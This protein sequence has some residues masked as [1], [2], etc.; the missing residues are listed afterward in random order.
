MA[1]ELLQKVLAARGGLNRWSGFSTV[2]GT[3]VTGAALRH[4]GHAPQD[5]TPRRVTVSTKQEWASV[6]SGRQSLS[7]SYPY[8]LF[9]IPPSL[10]HNVVH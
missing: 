8:P 6:P 3:I 2:H 9:R 1:T 7:R 5:P 4:E 10:F